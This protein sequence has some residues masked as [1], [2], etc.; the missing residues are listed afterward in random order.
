MA[1]P[2]T[3]LLSSFLAKKYFLTPN[4]CKYQQPLETIIVAPYSFSQQEQKSLDNLPHR[5]DYIFCN[6]PSFVSFQGPFSLVLQGK[7]PFTSHCFFSAISHV[8]FFSRAIISSFIACTQFLS[9]N[10]SC[11]VWGIPMKFRVIKKLLYSG[12]T[13]KR[14]Q[15]E[16]LALECILWF[17]F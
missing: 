3:F 17:L 16:K 11:K 4:C 5:L 8:S 7:H 6:Q 2:W 9:V 13:Y 14:I 15:S 1:V 12:T 10:A